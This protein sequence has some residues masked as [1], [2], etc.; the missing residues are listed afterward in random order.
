MTK[1]PGFKLLHG[2]DPVLGVDF[3][4]GPLCQDDFE[5]LAGCG[6]YSNDISEVDPKDLPSSAHDEGCTCQPDREMVCPAC[7]AYLKKAYPE[8]LPY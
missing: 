3:N 8:E 7:Q 2:H 6:M 4:K 5:F 1:T